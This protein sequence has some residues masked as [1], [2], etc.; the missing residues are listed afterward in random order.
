MNIPNCKKSNIPAF[1]VIFTGVI[2]IEK[3]IFLF[4]LPPVF[5]MFLTILMKHTEEKWIKQEFG[6][7][8]IEYCKKS[9]RGNSM[10]KK[11]NLRR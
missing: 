8:Y 1:T 9:K 5:W 11:I 7:E 3:N 10:V 6:E 4:I 2:L